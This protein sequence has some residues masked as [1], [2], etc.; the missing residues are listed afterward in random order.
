MNIRIYYLLSVISCFLLVSACSHSSLDTSTAP[1]RI[2]KEQMLTNI[3][4]SRLAE[5]HILL[6]GGNGKYKAN[7]ENSL[8]ADA[9]IHNDTLKVVGL[10]EGSTYI[11]VQS[12]DYRARLDVTIVSPDFMFSHDSIHLHPKQESKFVS[13]SGGDRVTLQKNDPDDILSVKWDGN[14]G[15]LE[16]NAHYEGQAQ[17]I[18][19]TP[20]GDQR[21]LVVTV[22]PIDQPSGL[23]IY[24]TG[25]KFYS[26][27]QSIR[28][29]MV[30]HRPGI[31]TLISNVA[32]PLGGYASTYS[33]SVLHISPVVN[34]RVG[35]RTTLTISYSI[36]G[37]ASIPAGN[38][39][40][41]IEKVTDDEVTL[42]GKRH[43]FILPY[44]KEEQTRFT[45]VEKKMRK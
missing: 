45:F 21:T 2:G 24:G 12:H 18:A 25:G 37:V 7:V 23:G 17:L 30:V 4:L 40:V 28:P 32:S 3:R 5:R 6:S 34:P 43:K 35:S 20:E 11:T 9:S 44:D 13:L 27:Q 41:Y 16:I 14:T 22:S 15:L 29:V 31:G 19:R 38:Y 10:L 39:P 33:G 36:G 1:I 8:V 42:R 26:N